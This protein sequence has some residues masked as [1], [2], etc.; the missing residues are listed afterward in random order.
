MNFLNLA[1]VLNF[2]LNSPLLSDFCFLFQDSEGNAMIAD[3]WS[4]HGYLMGLENLNLFPLPLVFPFVG[5]LS[6]AFCG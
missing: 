2:F 1:K 3:I 6:F 4:T 5:E